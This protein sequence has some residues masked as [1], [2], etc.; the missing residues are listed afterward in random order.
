MVGSARGIFARGPPTDK[1][2]H[3]P[4]SRRGL[5]ATGLTVAVV[6]TIG[7]VSTM[8]AGA[9]ETPA[10]AAV[11]PGRPPALLPWGATPR[12]LRTGRTG[13]SSAALAAA[14]ASASNDRPTRPVTNF[15]PKGRG[16]AP[17]PPSAAKQAAADPYLYATGSQD[18][19]TDGVGAL[20][21]V[22]RPRVAAADRHSLAEVA[23]RSADH[24]QAV[25]VGWTVD[26]L[27][28]GDEDTHL[29]V[30]HWVNGKQTCY[31][32]CGF[33]PYDGASIAPGATLAI[34][35]SKMF[36]IQHSAGAWWVAY[37]SEWIGSFPD[38]LW[39]STFTKT[40][41]VLVYGEVSAASLKP[42]T[43]MGTGVKPDDPASAKI[44]SVTYVNGPAVSLGLSTTDSELYPAV[45]S[46]ERSFR[47]GGPGATG[48]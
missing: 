28:N 21:T 48:C 6:A 22:A 4:I 16:V 12:P 10:A 40:G 43:A 11:E 18:A 31:N 41:Q 2:G 3:V 35:A 37:D 24:Q 44:S 36:G 38:T 23:V 33:V 32:A 13:A 29:F 26:R 19:A 1:D 30:F 15:A 25:E 47:Y 45:A 39:D 42:C 17:A 20:L 7:V 5:L 8:N 46:T 9:Q 14:G 27:T 34:G